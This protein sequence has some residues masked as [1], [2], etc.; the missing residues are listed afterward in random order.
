M[1]P[2]YVYRRHLPADYIR[3]LTLV[4]DG[5][6]FHGY[7]QEFHR[8]RL[9]YFSAL[10][11]CWSSRDERKDTTF[12][13]DEQ[14]LPVS[15]HLYDVLSNLN[16]RKSP[17]SSARIWIDAICINQENVHEK[18]IHVEHMHDV[19]SQAHNVI[20]WLGM[21]DGG[22]DLVLRPE[23][24]SKL[25]AALRL[26]PNS[27]I[28][29]EI[30]A[31][32]LPHF[33]DPIWKAIGKIC[34]RDW[35]F[36]TWVVQEISL[37]RSAELL[38]GTQQLGWDDFVDLVRGISRVGFLS[39]CQVLQRQGTRPDGLGVLMDLSWTRTMAQSNDMSVS[40][41]MHMIRLKEVTKP[42]DKVYGLL[43]ILPKKLRTAI[44]VDYTAND[45]AYWN[46]YVELA[47]QVILADNQ[48]FWL[49]CMAPS[50]ER[51]ERLPTWCP[52][53]NSLAADYL[54]F[55]N[56]KWRSGIGDKSTAVRGIRLIENSSRIKV[57]GF[58]IDVVDK[59]VHLGGPYSVPFGQEDRGREGNI[60]T[61]LERDSQCLDL[62]MHCFAA[63]NDAEA[64]YART[65]I[66]NTWISGSSIQS[67]ETE[68]VQSAYENSK[69][70]LANSDTG[71]AQTIVNDE[72]QQLAKQYITQLEWW[73]QRPFY[74]T[75]NGRIGRGTF[76]MRTGD[77]IVV[78]YQASPVFILR[79]NLGSGS[80]E[81]VGDAYLHGYMELDDIAEAGRGA[82]MEFIVS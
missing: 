45:V 61:F 49:L 68:R 42:V 36:R 38:C 17:S 51:P 15:Q 32:D 27:N 10:S 40:Y 79:E 69:T 73:R 77:V 5:E 4:S 39:A 30:A 58:Q 65:L 56:Q 11:W 2:R 25:N 31:P 33:D 16:P 81:L 47:K 54:D 71:N 24:I 82:D 63:S 13:C 28:A 34:D 43:G 35:F 52:N 60:C 19:Y 66:V 53:L 80:W 12:D 37:A 6:N 21:P 20:V 48:A 26:L 62:S 55:G 41:L 22:S 3:L 8:D 67:S 70:L 7:L 75:K 76:N 1:A 64:A 46:A 44:K 59:V 14:L 78:F 23:K 29:Q 57:L 74:T 72:R 18:N 50:R 9:P